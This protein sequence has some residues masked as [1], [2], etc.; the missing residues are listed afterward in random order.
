MDK[1]GDA[2][3]FRSVIGQ[4]TPMTEQNRIPPSQPSTQARVRNATLTQSIPDTLS[5]FPPENLAEDYLS[6][7]LSRLTLRKLRRSTIEDSLDLHGNPVEA[8][9]QLLLA[10]LH[11]A[12]EQQL[13]CVLVIHGKGTN[14]P[15]GEAV[16]RQHTRHWLAQHPQVLAFCSASPSV[17]GSG[18]VRIL[19]KISA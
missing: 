14:S 4:V 13:R 16:L 6:N 2:A 11:H 7:G 1:A 18:A 12:I 15:G 19:L 17:G 10:F 9:R 5:D 3:L 8:A